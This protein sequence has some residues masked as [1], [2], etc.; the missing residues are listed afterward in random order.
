MTSKLFT[1]LTLG[2]KKEPVQLLHRVVMAPLTRLR[3]GEQGVQTPLGAEYYKQRA[4]PGGLIIAE[5]TNIT[6]TARGSWGSPGIFATEQIE[7]WRSVTQAVHDKGAKMFLQLWHTGRISHPLNQPDGILPV[8]SSSK[9]ENM[10]AGKKIAT[11]EGRMEPVPPRALEASEIPSILADYR[12]AAENAVKAGFDGVELHAANGYL[13]EQFLHDGINDRTDMYGGS[14]QNR[15]RFLFEALEVILESLDSAKVGIRLS[16]FGGS[17]GDK[18]SDPIATYTYVLEKLNKYDLAYA[19]L[20]EP[21]GYHV[22]NPLAPEKGS[23]RQFRDTYKGVLI[24]ASGFDREAAV[25]IVDEGA[26]NAVAIGRHFISNPDLF[27]LTENKPGRSVAV[28]VL[29]QYDTVTDLRCYQQIKHVLELQFRVEQHTE[30]GD[31]KTLRVAAADNRMH[32]RWLDVLTSCIAKLTVQAETQ[33]RLEDTGAMWG[34]VAGAAK[35]A[36]MHGGEGRRSSVYT[37]RG[38]NSSSESSECSNNNHYESEI[39]AEEIRMARQDSTDDELDE[40]KLTFE[41][42]QMQVLRAADTQLH[43]QEY[44]SVVEPVLTEEEDAAY[45]ANGYCCTPDVRSSESSVC[46]EPGLDNNVDTEEETGGNNQED[47]PSEDESSA[48]DCGVNNLGTQSAVAPYKDATS[49]SRGINPYQE[50]DCNKARDGRSSLTRHPRAAFGAT[51]SSSGFFPLMQSQPPTHSFN[52]N[53][54]MF[55]LD[56][57]YQLVKSIGNGAYGAVI[58]VKDV[59]SDG[60]NLA[61]KKITNIFE[62]LVDAKRI[63]REVRLLHHF[64]H[65][66]ITHL[67]DLVPPPS[68]KQFNDMYIITDLMETD[69]HQVIYS[70]Q[71]MSDDHVKYFLYQMLCALH[72][73]HSAGVL[74]RDMKPSNILLNANCD[75]KV[76]DFG[77]ARGGVNLSSTIGGV[78][79]ESLQPGELTEYV[80]TR[81]Y[82]APEIMLNC[83]HYTAAIDVWAVGC[84]FAEMLLREP[85]FPGNDYLHQLKLIIKF[86]GTPK[87]EDIDFVKNTKALRFLTKLAISKPKKWL[88][89]FAGS[90]AAVAVSAEAIDLLNKMLLF[91]PEKRISVDAALR[92]PYLATFFDENDLVRSQPFDFS[93]DLPDEKLTKDAL[94]DLLCEDI[95]Q[96][97]PPVP[98]STA[99][100]PLNAAANRFFRMGMTASAMTANGVCYDPNHAASGTMDAASVAADM[101]TIKSHGFTTVRTYISK[102]GPT[103]IGP[104]ITGCNMTAALGVPYP[105]S[106]YTEQMEAA[107]AAAKTGGVGYIFVGNENLADATTVPSDMASVVRTIKSSVP[108]TVKV[109]TV[110]RNTEVINYSGISGWSELVA[111]C[112]VLGVNLH[113]YFNPGTTA[114]KAI[115]V[116]NNQWTIMKANF[117]DKLMITETGWPSEGSLS[118][119][120]GST[121]GAQTF[122]SDY[123]AWSSSQKESFYFQM[124]DTPYKSQAF[125]K[126]FGLLT[127]DSQ[128][129]F[130]LAA[131]STVNGAV[132]A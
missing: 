117:G 53:G 77:L 70:M 60:E 56:V 30:T 88:D 118:G 131:A 46:T 12:Q 108:P 21:R 48:E 92:H 122:F 96:F 102:F 78:R 28:V 109:G 59:I 105:Q 132:S 40:V 99:P 126:S 65:K 69:L 58:A 57:R 2:G 112:D 63:L 4:T 81:W 51:S 98:V 113:P 129:K 123:K 94:I 75:L 106:D 90:G 34:A 29:S 124:F 103:E 67:M 24:A 107:I 35:I 15:A 1:P 115:D 42:M 33:Q 72:H 128:D 79:R 66:N 74:H 54:Q 27:T 31:I 14:V 130:A 114:D 116:F 10:K 55:T 82:R 18:D 13:L 19:H 47:S 20:I 38:R 110:Q 121:A 95:E 120:I 101:A 104:I 86:L 23:A 44:A 5:A 83:L 76:C 52:A 93:F 119:N 89:V 68:R 97:H 45:S 7:A 8:S 91:N 62:D 73:I 32:A 49:V 37:T 85:L 61:V 36:P 50:T 9:M 17:F 111:A 64:N 3:T 22:R 16:P 39:P 71:P 125:E 127:S 26:A 43:S 87:Q 41:E 25:R 6:P 80:V 11:R 84:I 100:A